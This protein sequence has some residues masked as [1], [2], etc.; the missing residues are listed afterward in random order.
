M[1]RDMRKIFFVLMT[2]LML[3]TPDTVRAQDGGATVDDLSVD[4]IRSADTATLEDFLWLKRPVVVFAD[5]PADPQYVQQMQFL[6]SE[7]SA[8]DVRDVVIITDTD[9]RARSSFREKLR[10]RGFM[11][12]I[13]DKDG[14]VKHR[15]PLPWSVR[16]IGRAIDKMPTRQ[17]E[18]NDR[19]DVL[20]RG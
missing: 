9:P 3:H 12:A 1:L 6:T 17:Q 16:E 4:M 11:L 14:E 10:P 18:I 13:I 7:L 20:P 15:K 8:L 19:T 5:S 2:A